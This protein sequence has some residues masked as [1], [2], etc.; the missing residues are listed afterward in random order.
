MT[1]LLTPEQAAERIRVCVKT[2]RRLRQEGAIR[3]VAVTSRK[4]LYRP[5]DCDDFLASRVTTAVVTLFT[6]RRSAKRV[7]RTGNVASFTARRQERQAQG[8]R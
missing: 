6:Q 8:R 7:A 2:L 5:E 1:A 3:Y 4:I